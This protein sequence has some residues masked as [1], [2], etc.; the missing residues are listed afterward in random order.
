MNA[1]FRFHEEEG[2]VVGWTVVSNSL[3]YRLKKYGDFDR[4][5]H[6]WTGDVITVPDRIG[7]AI[8]VSGEYLNGVFLS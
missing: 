3:V 4:I 8:A 1:L 6:L 7:M 2:R 5:P